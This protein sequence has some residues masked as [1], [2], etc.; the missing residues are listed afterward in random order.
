M[1]GKELKNQRESHNL[2]QEELAKRT[3]ITQ[4]AISYWENNKRIPNIIE[5]VTLAD[6]Y[7]ITIDELI[8]HEVKKNW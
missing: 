4:A 6:F 3:K 5:C 7:G 2:S 8:G 1:Y